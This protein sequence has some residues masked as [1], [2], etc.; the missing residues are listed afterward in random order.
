MAS[1]GEPLEALILAA[2]VATA[3]VAA[4]HYGTRPAGAPMKETQVSKLWSKVRAAV[5]E[6]EAGSLR[7]A[8]QKTGWVATR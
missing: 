7:S 8:L 5:P 2:D 4:G 3:A 6:D 1:K